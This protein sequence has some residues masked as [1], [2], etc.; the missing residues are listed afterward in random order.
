MEA[1]CME[2]ALICHLVSAHGERAVSS[3]LWSAIPIT[4]AEH[5]P[6]SPQQRGGEHGSRYLLWT[7]KIPSMEY[8]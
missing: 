5:E 4:D 2:S 1:S 6:F 3:R 8:H 7:E